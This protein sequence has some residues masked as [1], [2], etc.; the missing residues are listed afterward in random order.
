LVV[1]SFSQRVQL[2]SRIWITTSRVDPPAIGQIL[3]SELKPQA[4]IG[5]G[6]QGDWHRMF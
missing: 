1:A 4:S 6:D 3:S 5:A 2:E